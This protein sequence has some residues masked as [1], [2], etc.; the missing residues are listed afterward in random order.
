MY[1]IATSKG[2]EQLPQSRRKVFILSDQ[3]NMEDLKNAETNVFGKL[4]NVIKVY[5]DFLPLRHFNPPKD[6]PVLL[7]VDLRTYD[8]LVRF[9]KSTEK[10][11]TT[12]PIT[13]EEK[14]AEVSRH[15]RIS[16]TKAKRILKFYKESLSLIFYNEDN[17]HAFLKEGKDLEYRRAVNYS[18]VLRFLIGDI[19][20]SKDNVKEVLLKY[21]YSKNSITNHCLKVAEE[22]VKSFLGEEIKNP[23]YEDYY[24]LFTIESAFLLI[25]QLTGALDRDLWRRLL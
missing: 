11:F 16:I 21:P 10:D 17:V 2:L 12:I 3:I 25:E 15:F 13:I 14:E 6:S 9:L 19:T 4:V 22:F 8:N 1:I 20:V 24:H 23:L 7:E 5:D 18:T